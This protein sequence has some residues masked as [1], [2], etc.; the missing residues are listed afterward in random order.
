MTINIYNIGEK[1]VRRNDVDDAYIIIESKLMNGIEHYLLKSTFEGR[2]AK[3]IWLSGFGLK[4]QFRRCGG[5][6]S[7]DRLKIGRI[8]LDQLFGHA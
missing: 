6:A 5:V 2:N 7:G 1:I 8:R 3:P 4:C